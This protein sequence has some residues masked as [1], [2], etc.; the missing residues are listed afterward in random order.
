MSFGAFSSYSGLWQSMVLDQPTNQLRTK[1]LS[2][3]TDFTLKEQKL[4]RVVVGCVPYDLHGKLQA[5]AY[6]FDKYSSLKSQKGISRPSILSLKNP[7]KQS[8]E[9]SFA[10]IKQQIASGNVYQVNLTNKFTFE[11][12]GSAQQWFDYIRSKFPDSHAAFLDLEY[13]QIISASPEMFLQIK[14]GRIITQP[15]KGTARSFDEKELINSP[16]E[17]AELAMI[18]DLLRNDLNTVC[19]PNSVRVQDSRIISSH[20][21]IVHT[22]AVISGRLL[23]HVTPIEALVSCLPGGSITGCPKIESVKLISR[24]ENK[25]RKY[26]TGV[27]FQILENGDINSSILIRTLEKQNQNFELGVG[28]GIVWDSD[29]DTEYKEMLSKAY[30]LNL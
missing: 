19:R 6:S 29:L 27:L 10:S 12:E 14:N 7:N 18:T 20:A 13:T 22:S 9:K 16:K 26:Y 4:G 28:S 11:S 24:L 5:V 23:G 21:D 30:L 1:N 17:Q 8:F 15:I 3:I 25:P 2:E